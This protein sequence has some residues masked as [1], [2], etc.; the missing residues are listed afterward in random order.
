MEYKYGD[1]IKVNPTASGIEHEEGV[2]FR[3]LV[4]PSLH[5]FNE[6]YIVEQLG[7]TNDECEWEVFPKWIIEEE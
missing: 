6:T 2:L 4:P 7:G 5:W 1:I 3:V